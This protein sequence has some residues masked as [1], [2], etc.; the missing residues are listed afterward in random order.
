[1]R[2]TPRTDGPDDVPFNG[3]PVIAHERLRLNLFFAFQ[4]WVALP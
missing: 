4:A 3:L 1:M 2:Q